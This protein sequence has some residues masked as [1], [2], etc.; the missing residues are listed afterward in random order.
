MFIKRHNIMKKRLPGIKGL[1]SKHDCEYY[2]RLFIIT[3][4]EKVGSISAYR[5][6]LTCTKTG[7]RLRK[8]VLSDREIELHT[9]ISSSKT[10]VG[11]RIEGIIIIE[12]VT[13]QFK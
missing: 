4:I 6:S 5:L 10:I 1:L 13:L 12:P 9:N 3:K 11:D 2:N 7:T 8:Y